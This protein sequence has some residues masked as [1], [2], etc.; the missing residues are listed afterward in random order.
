MKRLSWLFVLII[1]S[2]LLLTLFTQREKFLTP[3]DSQYWQERFEQSQWRLP[4]SKRILGDDGLYLYQAD[5]LIHGADPT[6]LNAE[7]PPLAKYLIGLALAAFNNGNLYGLVINIIVLIAFFF[8]AKKLLKK[9][10]FSLAATALLTLD[11]LFTDQYYKT[12]IDSTHL[13]FLL[14]FFLLLPNPIL[15]GAALGFFSVT[16]FPLLSPILATIVILPLL[17]NK[18]Y[19]QI[20]FFLI[21]AGMAVLLSYLR[22][23]TLG[24]NFIDWLK[25]QK[26][27]L[28]FYQ[29]S[30]LTANQ[31]SILS[32][33]LINQYQSLF[34][35]LKQ[36]SEQWSLAWPIITIIGI[37][38]LFRRLFWPIGFFV[39]IALIIYNLIPFWPRYLLIILP[40]L[41]L[42]TIQYLSKSKFV[43]YFIIIL[44]AFNAYVSFKIL[45]PTPQKA[46]SQ[47]LY[48]WEQGFFKDVY[49]QLDAASKQK[50]SRDKFNAIGQNFLYQAEIEAAKTELVNP[51]WSRWNSP[52]KVRIKVTYFT[53]Q[54]GPFTEEKDLIV[55]KE[56]GLWKFPWQWDL[57]INNL[58]EKNYLE[59]KVEEAKRGKII[60]SSQTVL[61]QDA[62]SYLIWITPVKIDQNQQEEI[63]NYLEALFD[64]R[65][66]AVNIHHR[67]ATK[68]LPE[69][70]IPIGV[71]QK[72]LT[73]EEK[74]KL[75]NYS[76]ITL[77]PKLARIYTTP[78]P[79]IG[80]VSN[81]QFSEC[82][83]LLYSTTNYDGIQGIEKEKNK[84][85]K[86]FNGN[87]LEIKNPEGKIVRTIIDS[88]KKDGQDVKERTSVEVYKLQPPI[89]AS[90]Q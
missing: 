84:I 81:S 45:V 59:T 60:D 83:S 5:K 40:F 68:Y 12:M 35:H 25:V 32:T 48:D 10:S 22:F 76:G 49:E 6:S 79:T 33:L 72:L 63:F 46:V 89:L 13:L 88:K 62:Q 2:H 15:A 29:Q 50:I 7:V 75:E 23:F 34:S 27:I 3:Y 16:K 56:K 90:G 26:W 39:L 55:I 47:F 20:F 17:K 9:T 4:L 53:R 52:Q 11:P 36:S 71:P 74:Q 28:D 57:L 66:S 14:L 42:G 80:R 73:P 21:A 43:F 24:H 65:I 70:P 82:C 1:I 58:A 37:I 51:Q 64:R 78:D 18:K 38:G 44:L 61:A 41:Y 31:G 30:K 8:L 77:T 86:G 87:R 19:N 54:L 69:Y 85:L 67:Y